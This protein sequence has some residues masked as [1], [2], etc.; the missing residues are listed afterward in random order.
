MREVRYPC[1]QDVVR[2]AQQLTCT[3]I[4]A[5]S[6]LANKPPAVQPVRPLSAF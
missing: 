4:R 5:M 2:S 1:R 6:L 3:T